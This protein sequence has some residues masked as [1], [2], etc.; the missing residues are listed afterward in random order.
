MKKKPTKNFNLN[1]IQLFV[2]LQKNETFEL[3][4][5]LESVTFF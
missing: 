2:F 5:D 3:I 4:I 1:K